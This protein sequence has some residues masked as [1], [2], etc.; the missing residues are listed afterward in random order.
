MQ[1]DSNTEHAPNHS[2]TSNR[3]HV[4]EDE[5]LADVYRIFGPH[6]R[7]TRTMELATADGRRISMDSPAGDTLAR[8]VA[9]GPSKN[10]DAIIDILK[11]ACQRF[12]ATIV[13]QQLQALDDPADRALQ[14]TIDNSPNNEEIVLTGNGLFDLRPLPVTDAD[15]FD[16][17]KTRI[18]QSL[19]DVNAALTPAGNYELAA[20]STVV[21]LV[22]RE[23]K[24]SGDAPYLI[25]HAL[26]RAARRI[27][28]LRDADELPRDTAAVERLYRA[29]NAIAPDL[30][31][32]DRQVRKALTARTAY[33]LSAMTEAEAGE[34]R[35]RAVN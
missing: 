21:A 16:I 23:L 14:P 2:Q 11:P 24:R 28:V 18:R 25:Y 1:T 6:F 9:A 10:A 19:D 30:L 3:L 27:E 22:E 15:A 20:L 33:H 7:F 35:R 26:M 17:A 4:V 31:G 13:R 34:L 5:T 8:L 29:L 32:K 12:D